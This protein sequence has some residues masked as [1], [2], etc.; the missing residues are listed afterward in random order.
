MPL[1]KN[2]GQQR[3]SGRPGATPRPVTRDFHRGRAAEMWTMYTDGFSIEEIAEKFEVREFTI[4]TRLRRALRAHLSKS[5][6][7]FEQC[8]DGWVA[9]GFN[10]ANHFQELLQKVESLAELKDVDLDQVV[11]VLAEC[12]NIIAIGS[13]F[14]EAKSAR[15]LGVGDSSQQ[16]G[17]AGL[18]SEGSRAGCEI[19]TVEPESERD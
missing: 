14:N 10:T 9:D 6:G 16:S 19:I 8:V 3:K 7:V 4:R 1:L 2:N 12:R 15:G 13:A 5:P 17:N 11:T 18:L